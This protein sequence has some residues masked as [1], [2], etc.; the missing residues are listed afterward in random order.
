MPDSFFLRMGVSVKSG[1]HRDLQ[2][3]EP[4]VVVGGFYKGQK[5]HVIGEK[6]LTLPFDS[7]FLYEVVLEDGLS[8][9]LAPG[10]IERI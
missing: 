3:K 4:I 1:L 5:G 8:L 2:Y 7:Q 6:L 10:Q 9:S